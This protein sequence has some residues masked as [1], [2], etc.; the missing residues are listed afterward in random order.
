MVVR[1]TTRRLLFVHVG[2]V[3][4]L[5]GGPACSPSG[6][7]PS[8]SRAEDVGPETAEA[9]CPDDIPDLCP[10]PM[11]SWM[12]EVEP[13]IDQTCNPCHGVG[14]VEQFSRFN[15]STYAG[16]H[17][18]FGSLLSNVGSCLMPPPDAGAL[19]LAERAALLGW[20][21]CMAPNN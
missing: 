19:K 13:I 17:N 14:G 6:P 18:N 20:L 8:D 5:S 10:S 12:G 3:I 9:G 11:P 21:V 16:V 2:A 7:G 4:A 1:R 15:F